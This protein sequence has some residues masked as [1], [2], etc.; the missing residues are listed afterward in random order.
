MA[1]KRDFQ[2][3]PVMTTE[4]FR[5]GDRV[6]KSGDYFC[7]PCR[8]QREKHHL[9][10]MHFIEGENFSP[11]PG[12]GEGSFWEYEAALTTREHKRIA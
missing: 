3:P 10:T 1:H 2:A 6:P 7:R 12:C 5:P 9:F 4:S 11:C 8:A